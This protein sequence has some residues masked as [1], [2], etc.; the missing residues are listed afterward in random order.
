MFGYDTIAGYGGRGPAPLPFVVVYDAALE[1]YANNDL[2]PALVDRSGNNFNAVQ[3]TPALQFQF[4]TD[5][6][7]YYN[8]VSVGTGQNKFY[9]M[10]NHT[11]KIGDRAQLYLVIRALAVSTKVGRFLGESNIS[12]AHTETFSNNL[13]EPFATTVRKDN[14][15]PGT[16]FSSGWVVYR[17]VSRNNFYQMSVN[18]TPFFTTATNTFS[19]SAVNQFEVGKSDGPECF[20]RLKYLAILN[21]DT[22]DLTAAL[23]SR[24]GI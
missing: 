12:G 17:V 6:G 16:T 21:D 19:K 8:C 18:G 4:K 5:D 7:P 22:T 24:F 11:G 15:V 10:P 14:Q 3:A 2:M 23:R 9:L 13:F 1:S 20:Y